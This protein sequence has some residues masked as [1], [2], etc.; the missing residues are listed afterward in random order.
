MAQASLSLCF[1]GSVRMPNISALHVHSRG[2]LWFPHL[3]RIVWRLSGEQS[4]P[5]V[6]SRAWLM[7]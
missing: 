1:R 7:L 5:V 6:G 2:Q 3:P 4:R